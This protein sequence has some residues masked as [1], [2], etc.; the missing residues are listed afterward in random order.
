MMLLGLVLLV[1]LGFTSWGGSRY[2]SWEPG[3]GTSGLRGGLIRTG[4]T[5]PRCDTDLALPAGRG[6]AL[7]G[8]FRTRVPVP[9]RRP[10]N[11]RKPR[12]PPATKPRAGPRRPSSRSATSTRG[13]PPDEVGGRT[14]VSGVIDVSPEIGLPHSPGERDVRSAAPRIAPTMPMYSVRTTLTSISSGQ[15]GQ[16]SRPLAWRHRPRMTVNAF[17]NRYSR[18]VPPWP[19]R[20]TTRG[21]SVIPLVL[22]VLLVLVFV[23]AIGAILAGLAATIV[24]TPFAPAIRIAR[25]M[26]LLVAG[27]VAISVVTIV[28]LS[29]VITDLRDDGAETTPTQPPKPAADDDV[30]GS[31]PHARTSVDSGRRVRTGST[32][33]LQ[34]SGPAT[35]PPAASGSSLGPPDADHGAHARRHRPG[36]A[37]HHQPLGDGGH[38]DT[39]FRSYSVLG[40]LSTRLPHPRTRRQALFARCPR[41]GRCDAAAEPRGRRRI[42]HAPTPSRVSR[43]DDALARGVAGCLSIR[44]CA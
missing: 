26:P 35:R 13:R 37:Q 43:A 20:P 24:V 22:P 40:A 31:R 30:P 23:P 1:G 27:R 4:S 12:S 34:D 16:R 21:R 42:A 38:H 41:D 39:A 15:D 33:E 36:S 25:S 6:H 5:C 18:V 11:T 7:V 9:V 28:L 29:G 32:G 17:A 44:S 8:V 2:A 19:V 14:C 10:R 3:A